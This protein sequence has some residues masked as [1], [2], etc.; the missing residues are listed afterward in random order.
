MQAGRQEKPCEFIAK[1]I[2]LSYLWV[3]FDIVIHYIFFIKF[4]TVAFTATNE[5]ISPPHQEQAERPPQGGD[6]GVGVVHEDLLPPLRLGLGHE[7]QGD[8][9][10]RWK[11]DEILKNQQKT[12][13]R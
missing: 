11:G 12:F 6:D 7:V 5:L 8:L 1:K 10:S 4:A 3:F 13:F 2:L 9:R